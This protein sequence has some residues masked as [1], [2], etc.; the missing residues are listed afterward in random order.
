MRLAAEADVDPRTAEKALARGLSSI[1]ARVVR[2]R[3]AAAAK[4]LRVKLAR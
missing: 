4:K 3:V 2:E 1:R